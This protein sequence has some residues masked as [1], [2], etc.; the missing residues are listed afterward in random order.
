MSLKQTM[1]T[2]TSTA[3]S[4]SRSRPRSG[5]GRQRCRAGRGFLKHPLRRPAV[6]LS[7]DPKDQGLPLCCWLVPT[8]MFAA[9]TTLD[10]R[11][12]EG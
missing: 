1:S 6:R 8:S 4:P 2:V 9:P 10:G 11:A 12:S 5:N 7:Q 3:V